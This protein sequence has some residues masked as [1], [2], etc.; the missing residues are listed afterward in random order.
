MLSMN[1]F[2]EL[3]S[4]QLYLCFICRIRKVQSLK[5]V[6][7]T[8]MTN[9]VL[10]YHKRKGS[11]GNLIQ[12]WYLQS[13]AVFRK[14]SKFC[15][16]LIELD[17]KK[18]RR[19][20]EYKIEDVMSKEVRSHFTSPFDWFVMFW[21]AHMGSAWFCPPGNHVAGKESQSGGSGNGS[22]YFYLLF[23]LLCRQI[24]FQVSE[25]TVWFDNRYIY[26]S[27]PTGIFQPCIRTRP[28]PRR[29]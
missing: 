22:F 1:I 27:T 5:K 10:L 21:S 26:L 23:L 12:S 8:V 6:S 28:Q 14:C 13:T 19:D 20:D 3:Y 11:K 25:D 29:R 16:V 24:D 17:K 2:S 7:K 18:R 4:F 15:S 9:V